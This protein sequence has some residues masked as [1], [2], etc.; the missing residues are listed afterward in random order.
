ML[1]YVLYQH[2]EK[3]DFN[4]LFMFHSLTMPQQ[5][6]YLECHVPKHSARIPTAFLRELPDRHRRQSLGTPGGCAAVQRDTDRLEKWHIGIPKLNKHKHNVLPLRRSTHKHNYRLCNNWRTTGGSYLN[7]SSNGP[8][9]Q[10]R[11][12]QNQRMAGVGW[13]L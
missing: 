12:P 7:E 8:L 4:Q 11:V 13:D 9:T 5:V 6:S 10:L 2:T 1:L 3:Q